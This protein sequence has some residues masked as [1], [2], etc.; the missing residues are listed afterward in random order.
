[1]ITR[2]HGLILAAAFTVGIAAGAAWPPPPL[3]KA[4]LGEAAWSLP[5]ATDLLRYVPQDMADVTASMRWN[6]SQG[7]AG[8]RGAWRLIGIVNKGGVIAILIAVADKPEDVKR[9][10]IGELLPDGSVLQAVRGDAAITK[11]DNCLTTYQPY[12]PEAVERSAGCEEP[13]ISVQ[14]TIQ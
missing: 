12:L 14:G 13:E 4:K 10:T 1:M 3:P 11:R 8:E 5:A 6:G 2:H 7:G 9:V